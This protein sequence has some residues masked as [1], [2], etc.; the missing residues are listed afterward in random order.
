MIFLTFFHK[1]YV[2]AI[3]LELSCVANV[4][5]EGGGGGG[6]GVTTCYSCYGVLIG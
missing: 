5:G 4:N 3:L 1:T 6:S 2:V